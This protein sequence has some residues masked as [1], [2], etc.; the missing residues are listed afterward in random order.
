VLWSFVKWYYYVLTWKEKGAEK[1]SLKVSVSNNK[2]R[3]IAWTTYWPFSAFWTILDQP[4]KR[5]FNMVFKK[6]E[7]TYNSILNN[8][9]KD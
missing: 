2:G 1:G 8:I 7:N 5:F 9:Y 3:I 4:V 6:F